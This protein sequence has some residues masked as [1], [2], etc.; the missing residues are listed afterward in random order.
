M[1]VYLAVADGVFDN[2]LFCAVLFPYEMSWMRYGTEMSQL[3]RIFPTYSSIF[4]L[5]QYKPVTPND[6]KICNLIYDEVLADF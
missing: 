5:S 2:V 4:K 3:L 1:A 6:Q